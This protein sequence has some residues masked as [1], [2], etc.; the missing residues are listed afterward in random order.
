M[1]DVQW[2][3]RG[4]LGEKHGRFHCHAVLNGL[5]AW[6]INDKT[7]GVAASLWR[8]C[9]GGGI[10]EI[11]RYIPAL[12]GAGYLVKGLEGWD[13]HG[14]RLYELRKF[15]RSD[16]LMFSRSCVWEIER[17]ARR[18]EAWATRGHDQEP[19]QGRL[20][21]NPRSCVQ[22]STEGSNCLRSLVQA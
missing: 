13:V 22:P 21:A 16:V 4:E 20:G 2:I 18:Y 8:G 19:P 6:A 3:L 14:A 15:G 5:P 7:L 12:D 10:A 1:Y 9:R 17:R 11:E